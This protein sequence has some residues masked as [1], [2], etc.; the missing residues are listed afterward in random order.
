M[1]AIVTGAIATFPVGGVAWDYGQYALGLERLGFE[2][3][4]LEDS[5]LQ[6]YDPSIRTYGA[7][8]S[9]GAAFLKRTLAELSPGLATRWHLRGPD[10]CSHGMDRARLLEMVASADLFLNVSGMCMLRDE[11]MACKR[12]VLIDTDPGWNQFVVFPREDAGSCW[13]GT[14]GFRGHDHFFT[15]AERMGET[16]CAIPDLGLSWMPTRPPVVIDRWAA[17]STDAR[18]TTVM[19]WNN[20]GKP[21]EHEGR[22]YSSKEP[23]FARIEGL[24]SQVPY[25]FEIAV[26]GVGPPVEHWRELGWTVVDSTDISVTA[27]DY[28]S[29]VQGSRGEFSVAKN[30]YVATHSGWFSCRSACY[31]AS[32]RPVV[33]QDTGFSER[34][35]CGNGLHAFSTL[36]SAIE[37]IEAVEAD[38]ARHSAAAKEVARE[39]LDSDR[40]LRH[41][42]D[43]VGIEA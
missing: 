5:G 29:Y 15:Y 43:R 34:I 16:S 12:K 19:T 20:Y 27:A 10:G 11:Y 22:M 24:P 38:Y 8:A 42:L 9:Y 41:L 13:P 32:G 39:Y 26:G 35:P 28:Q 2:V 1:K 23:E 4:Y 31:L 37:G 17:G 7:D 36:E 30:V 3:F 33:V 25:Q 40:V 21:I 18:W 14:Q 6:M